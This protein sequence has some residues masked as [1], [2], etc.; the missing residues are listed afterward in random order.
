[1]G[2]TNLAGLQGA[3]W[4]PD[5]ANNNFFALDFKGILG[6]GI[7]EVIFVF[8]F[9]ELFDTFGTMVATMD[10]AGISNSLMV[11]N[12]YLKQ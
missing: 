2:V 7:L 9:V 11:V 4:F 3:S 6:I 10:R 8:T 12:D 1:M 5:F